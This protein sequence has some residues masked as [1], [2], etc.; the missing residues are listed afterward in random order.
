MKADRII[1]K[2][3]YGIVIGVRENDAP[4]VHGRAVRADRK[5]EKTKEIK[6]KDKRKVLSRAKEK[7]WAD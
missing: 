7:Y 2:S 4:S 1:F 6:M 5:E 3:E